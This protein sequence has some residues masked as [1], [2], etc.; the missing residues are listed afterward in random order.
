MANWA[1]LP[2]VGVSA[3]MSALF[4]GDARDLI[5]STIGD[6]LLG[7]LRE[8]G[9]YDR[10]RD[11]VLR[12]DDLDRLDW[13]ELREGSLQCEAI[14]LLRDTFEDVAR[15]CAVRDGHQSRW[16]DGVNLASSTE[17]GVCCGGVHK[18]GDRDPRVGWVGIGADAK[19]FR[20]VTLHVVTYGDEDM[21]T[22]DV[23][24]LELGDDDY[25][26]AVTPML[27]D[28]MAKSDIVR[29]Q[30][31]D[32]TVLV[33]GNF[34]GVQIFGNVLNDPEVRRA[35]ESELLDIDGAS[36]DEVVIDDRAPNLSASIPVRVGV[37]QTEQALDDLVSP[38]RLEW[39]LTN[40]YAEDGVTELGW[41]RE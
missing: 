41:W 1:L 7:D 37:L 36:V 22:E 32:S 14:D 9:R 21:L 35:V 31:T 16:R 38:Y 40:V 19:A 11:G 20:Q 26:L 29:I 12:Y 34:F 4:F 27:A 25:R 33:R 28:D 10:Y 8:Y 30:G 5:R 24:A 17:L 23:E 3:G 2:G 6:D 18:R 13:I 39:I 15:Y